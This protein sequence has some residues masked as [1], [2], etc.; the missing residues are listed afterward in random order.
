[1]R[2]LATLLISLFPVCISTPLAEAQPPQRIPPVPVP[3]RTQRPPAPAPQADTFAI[4]ASIGQTATRS[5]YL[6]NGFEVKGGVEGYVTPRLSIRGQVG[7]SWWDIAGLSYAG[8]IQP[9]YFLANV[10]YNWRGEDWRPYVTGGGGLYRYAFKEVGV[11]GSKTKGGVDVGGGV[12]YFV[13]RRATITGEGLFHRVG[14]VPTNRAVLGFKGSFWS[15][16]VGAKK[17][18]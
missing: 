9:A 15:F 14:V 4:H 17:Y 7:A 5:Q 3:L 11:S 1:M 13:T 10:V 18:F 8:S 16:A 2:I 6:D 12:E